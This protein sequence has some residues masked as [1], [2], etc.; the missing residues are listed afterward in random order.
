M[1]RNVVRELLARLAR[2][3]R[4]TA[5]IQVW[6]ANTDVGK[7]LVSVGLV[8][9]V[10]RRAGGDDLG[11]PGFSR[12]PAEQ[13]PSRGEHRALYLK[14]MQTGYPAD[15]D[16]RKVRRTEERSCS[17]AHLLICSFAP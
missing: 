8:R 2:A 5:C 14:P 17:P 9:E 11:D 12:S 3:R 10:L 16:E 7:T 6:G 13:T 4:T 1:S 15:S